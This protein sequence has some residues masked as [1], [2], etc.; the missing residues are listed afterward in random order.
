MLP[1]KKPKGLEALKSL[2]VYTGMPEG[3]KDAT[4]I[5]LSEADVSNLRGS[6]IRVSDLAH[7][8]GW[9]E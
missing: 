8:I 4:K 1:R 7:N 9:K 6:Y 2:K 3:F 5:T